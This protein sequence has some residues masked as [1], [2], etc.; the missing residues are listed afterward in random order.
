MDA[1]VVVVGAGPVGLLLAAE[2]ALAG[3]R[4]IVLERLIA[5]TG[6][7]KARGVGVLA[8]EA[9]RSR[10]LGA[11]LDREHE[12]GLRALARDHGTTRTHFAWI[13]K[14][15]Q[16]TADPGRRGALIGQPAL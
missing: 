15:D 5:P 9:L 6:Q 2:L 12:H 14:V 13:H 11:D 10:G 3:A 7:P 8:A 1:D 16:D 4:P